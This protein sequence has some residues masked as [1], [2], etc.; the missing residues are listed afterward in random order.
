M[1]SYKLIVPRILLTAL[2]SPPYRKYSIYDATVDEWEAILKI[3]YDWRFAEI[4]K[5]CCRELEKYEIEPVRKISMYQTHEL[6]KKLLIP[7]YAALTLRAEPL[8]FTEGRKLGLET[9]L[10]LATARE[11]ARVSPSSPSPSPSAASL[12]DEVLTAIIRDIFQLSAGPPSPDLTPIDRR[13]VTF[14][15][16][17]VSPRRQALAISTSGSSQPSRATSPTASSTSG[18]QSFGAAADAI[19]AGS[20][21]G[22]ANLLGL[23]SENGSTTGANET[24]SSTE[25]NTTGTTPPAGENAAGTGT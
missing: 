1:R 9:A 10:M 3:A 17:P 2:S 14:A 23:N 19:N 6:D 7:S 11:L 5:L 24:T 8:S 15:A 13:T 18:V 4:K 16:T 12:N 20:T 22:D 25:G 21:N